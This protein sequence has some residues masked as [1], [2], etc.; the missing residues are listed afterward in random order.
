MSTSSLGH[1][2]R[3]RRAT[4]LAVAIG[5]LSLVSPTV[6]A[7]YEPNDTFLQAVGPLVGGQSYDATLENTP[8]EDFFFFNVS[9]QRQLD[10][11]VTLV[12]E[13]ISFY[14]GVEA[15]LY[16][17][18][19][20]VIQGAEAG[21]QDPGQTGHIKFTSPN[22]A[23]YVVRIHGDSASDYRLQVTPA[24]ALI[25][26]DPGLV[27]TLGKA[28]GPDDVQ[29]LFVDGQLI[30]ETRASTEQT[31]SLGALPA[32]SQI[33]VEAVNERDQWSWNFS[34]ANQGARARTTVIQE[35]QSGD[36][37][38]KATGT[39]RRVT[40]TPSGGVINSCGLALA[41]IA[42]DVLPTPTP[43]A[44]VDDPAPIS[45]RVS[46]ERRNGRYRGRVSAVVP[47]CRK[48][49]RVELRRMGKGTRSYGS[50]TTRDDG[51]WTIKSQPKPG[52]IYAVVN[53]ERGGAS[54]AA[55]CLAAK[56]R[57][58]QKVR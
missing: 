44:G 30:G 53:E 20:H 14:D 27:A 12:S 1:R 29:R 10:I 31:F 19:G 38:S 28:N 32:T 17:A 11:A 6:A 42:C 49:V 37:D 41:S 26:T 54:G 36:F 52:K 34:V 13:D 4:W 58:L 57:A 55:L 56:S 23:Q 35:K 46:I 50:T 25:Q 45:R 7:P 18:D 40:F 8:D 43:E 3:R 48:N 47:G 5:Q 24:D 39:V 15:R 51:S 21:A 9:G 33:T 22:S 16:D 2:A